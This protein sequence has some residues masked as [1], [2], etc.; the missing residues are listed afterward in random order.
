MSVQLI[1]QRDPAF[2]EDLAR[3]FRPIEVR[4]KNYL[5]TLVTESGVRTTYNRRQRRIRF[6]AKDGNSVRE[7][8]N[9]LGPAT[10]EQGY[11]LPCDGEVEMAHVVELFEWSKRETIR[12]AAIADAERPKRAERWLKLLADSSDE[13]GRRINNVSAFGPGYTKQRGS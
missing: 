4:E 11:F 6:A 8:V 3:D 1:L 5:C 13:A 9:D 2:E 10:S 12:R 7:I